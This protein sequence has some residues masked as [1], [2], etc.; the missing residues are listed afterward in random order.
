MTAPLDAEDAAR[1]RQAV[2]AELRLLVSAIRGTD[3]RLW[4]IDTG[5][6]DGACR[7]VPVSAMSDRQREHIRRVAW[8]LRRYL[9]AHLRPKLNPDDPIVREM[10]ANEA[11][12]HG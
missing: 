8:R 10:H 5:F 3:R 9:P 6:V 1:V 7:C 2:D 4:G 12:T 11:A